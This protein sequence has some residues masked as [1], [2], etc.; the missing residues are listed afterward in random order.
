[1]LS[2][3]A[4]Y[5]KQG[6]NKY[7]I[8]YLR[9]DFRPLCIIIKEIILYTDH[10]N[11]LADNKEFLKYTEI[12]NKILDLFNKKFN[13]RGLYNKPTHN[14]HVRTKICPY[15]ENFHGNKKRT[16]DEYYGNSILLIES[17]C[18]AENKHYPLIFLDKFFEKHN[19]VPGLFKELVQVT[20][21][22]DDDNSNH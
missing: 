16:K 22:S 20:D 5:G 6:A 18:E 8:G 21:Y 12:W 10:M 1:M 13:K 14:E 17:I 4:S 2:N 9:D 15:N 3:K 7:Y 19:S 11:I